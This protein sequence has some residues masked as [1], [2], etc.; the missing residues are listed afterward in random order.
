[1]EIYSLDI[2]RFLGPRPACVF[3]LY[4]QLFTISEHRR[5]VVWELFF[6]DSGG[7]KNAITQIIWSHQALEWSFPESFIWQT[8]TEC[9]LDARHG[10]G[11]EVG[12][13]VRSDRLRGSHFGGMWEGRA[14][15]KSKL[16]QVTP[17]SLNAGKRAAELR[18]GPGLWEGRGGSW[19]G[20]KRR[21]VVA[22][23][24]W[25]IPWAEEPAGLLSSEL[26][27]QSQLSNYPTNCRSWLSLPGELQEILC[28]GEA[29]AAEGARATR[30][31]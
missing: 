17:V 3:H 24:A 6:L 10:A 8:F 22:V 4:D 23:L 5:G 26:Q 30:T 31:F 25:E 7:K 19:E 9:L 14:S 2:D 29:G 28:G 16:T 15:Q 12:R 13:A 27:S 11:H 18:G 20:F 21:S 1:M